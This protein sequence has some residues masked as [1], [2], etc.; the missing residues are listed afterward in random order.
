MTGFAAALELPGSGATLPIHWASPLLQQFIACTFNDKAGSG[1]ED[2]PSKREHETRIENKKVYKCWRK[3]WE[4]DKQQKWQLEMRHFL[5]HVSTA[6]KV[7]FSNKVIKDCVFWN[8]FSFQTVTGII[9]CCNVFTIKMRLCS[10]LETLKKHCWKTYYSKNCW[11]SV[12][13]THNDRN[14]LTHIV[15]LNE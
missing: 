10:K 12:L 14:S 13:D 4:S 11:R 5:S 15:R 3:I 8:S 9:E 6:I 1:I 2:T 7:Q